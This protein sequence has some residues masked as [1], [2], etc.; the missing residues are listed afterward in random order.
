MLQQVLS[1]KQQKR[2]LFFVQIELLLQFVKAKQEIDYL[3]FGVDSKEQ[4]IENI[5][6]FE[7]E[8]EMDCE[9][10]EDIR[11]YF[12]K[13]EDSVILPSLWANGKKVEKK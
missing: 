5:E 2:L 9:M 10:M 12:C 8:K 13:V 11:T 4:L 3:V 1:V 7:L 6:K